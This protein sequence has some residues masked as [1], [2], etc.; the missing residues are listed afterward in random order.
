MKKKVWLFIPCYNIESHIVPTLKRIPQEALERL[1]RVLIVDNGSSDKTLSVTLDYLKTET[2]LS[3]TEVYQNSENYYLG[4]STYIAFS[5]A[6]Q[7]DVDYVICLH[8]D[9]QAPPEELPQFLDHIDSPEDYDFISGSRFMEESNTQDYSLLR[10]LGNRVF[11][12]WQKVILKQEIQDLGAY[13]AFNMK[14]ISKLPIKDIPFDM[15]YHPYLVLVAAKLSSRQLRIKEFPIRWGAVE[16]SHVNIWSYAS[17]HFSR[18]IQLSVFKQARLKKN[19]KVLVT[20]KVW[21]HSESS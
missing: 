8:S 3:K 19:N 4:G 14:T 15:G 9:G 16:V 5:K 20:V 11:S 17:V 13:L 7:D 2:S 21:P 1:D 12:A 18:L 6:L 10:N